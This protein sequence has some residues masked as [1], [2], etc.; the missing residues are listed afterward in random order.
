M[1]TGLVEPM[2]QVQA[3]A[4]QDSLIP[5]SQELPEVYGSSP[6]NVTSRIEKQPPP[7]TRTCKGAAD[8]ST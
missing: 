4:L 8:F 6:R 7:P 5:S 1:T 3:H 2:E